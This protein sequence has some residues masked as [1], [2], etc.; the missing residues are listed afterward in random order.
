M[1]RFY[2]VELS[3]CDVAGRLLLYSMPGRFEP[4][5]EFVIAM[6]AEEIYCIL[7]L[8]SDTEIRQKSP[9]YYEASGNE[10]FRRRVLKMP[11]EDYGIPEER[12]KFSEVMDILV[13]ALDAG[14]HVLIHCAAGVGRTGMAAVCLLTDLGLGVEEATK[15]VRDARSEPETEEQKQF[16]LDYVSKGPRSGH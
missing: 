10:I 13:A 12:E 14:K 8:V 16:I 1:S 15:R 6:G 4:I 9:G 3:G 2:E 11:I 5:S 7:C